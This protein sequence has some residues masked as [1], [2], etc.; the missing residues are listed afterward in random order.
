MDALPCGTST[1]HSGRLAVITLQNS[2]HCSQDEPICPNQGTVVST[3]RHEN[4]SI[5]EC[6]LTRV[7]DS[8]YVRCT[9]VEQVLVS[10]GVGEALDVQVGLAELVAL[11]ATAAAA[12]GR[13]PRVDA[14]RRRRAKPR[15]EGALLLLHKGATTR[16]F[17][18]L[19]Q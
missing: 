10:G 14:G 7:P 1:S 16:L 9:E 8:F 5:P 3:G 13:A 18:R 4:E 12:T 11:R 19:A 2:S 6:D 15:R 17:R